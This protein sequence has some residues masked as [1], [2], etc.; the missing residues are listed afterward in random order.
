MDKKEIEWIKKQGGS[1]VE[2]VTQTLTGKI[3]ERL[4]IN[5]TDISFVRTL[6]SKYD[7]GHIINVHLKKNHRYK[8][9]PMRMSVDALL[10][11]AQDNVKKLVASKKGKKTYWYI[12]KRGEETYTKEGKEQM[13]QDYMDYLEYVNG[14]HWD[15]H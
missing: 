15:N 12:D 5:I 8:D 13:S 9:V 3:S 14:Y 1:V 10:E 11:F 7:N 2:E 4:Y 6:G